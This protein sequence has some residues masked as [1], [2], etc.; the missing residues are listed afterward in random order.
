METWLVTGGAGFIGSCFVRLVLEQRP[1]V[2][3]VV[4]DKLT[5]AGRLENLTALPDPTRFE[6]VRGDIACHDD[7]APLF[8]RCGPTCV[9]NLA[10]E[11]HV[12]RSIDGPRACVETNLLGT[13]E[14]LETARRHLETRPEAERARFRLLHVSTDEVY[15]SL[16][17]EGRFSETTPYAPNSPTSSCA[18]IT[19]PTACPRS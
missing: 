18:P 14:L 2:R 4:L 16:G 17:P 12:D 15:G 9:V 8:A 3:V 5:Y 1:Q 10:A 19:E 13:F 7:V 11:T 6:L